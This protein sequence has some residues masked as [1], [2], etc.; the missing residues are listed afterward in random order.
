VRRDV[1]PLVAAG[2][3]AGIA[4]AIYWLGPPG[5]DTP[6]HL[7]QTWLYR[8][9]GFVWWNNSWYSGRYVFVAYSVL[10]YPLAAKL[11]IGLVSV[12][13]ATVMTAA[14]AWVMIS[15]YGVR[16]ALAPAILFAVVAPYDMMVSGAYPFLCG[17]AALAVALVCVQKGWRFGFAVAALVTLGFSPLALVL[18]AVIMAGVVFGGGITSMLGR[19]RVELGAFICVL[20]LAV[21]VEHLFSGGG[22]SYPY[23]SVDLL[24]IGSFCIAGFLVAGSTSEARGLKAMFAI[25]LAVNMAAY[26]I[27]APVGS[28]A[29]RLFAEAGAPLLLLTRNVANRRS[30]FV[31]MVA[32]VALVL[33]V[34]PFVRDMSTAWSNPGS[35]KTFWQPAVTYLEH[36]PSDHQYRVE[37]VANW[38]HWEALYMPEAGFSI[39]RGWYRQDD[40]PQNKALYASHLRARSYDHW[41]R[42]V[43]VRYVLLPR[44]PLDPSARAEARLLRSGDSGLTLLASVG[45]FDIYRLPHA[46]PIL[47]GPGTPR[48]ISLK[49]A[50]VTFEVSEPGT[51][52]VRVR[53]TSWQAPPGVTTT[54]SPNGMTEVTVPFAGRVR[55]HYDPPLE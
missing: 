27:S 8:H 36:H 18:L 53:N 7:F 48:L 22:T 10:F 33:Q 15:R 11:G 52:L 47:T 41:L 3:A 23:G 20:A 55:L 21:T 31:L 12:I 6:A 14:T 29:G 44:G 49:S 17:A 19:H 40:F 38:G 43:G 13:A 42:S 37:V 30:P 45:N 9:Q 5:V 28:N 46:T 54:A 51:Y 34:G 1:L 35:T 50:N 39:A 2:I 32:A 25:Y 26:M 24:V 4:A 16:S